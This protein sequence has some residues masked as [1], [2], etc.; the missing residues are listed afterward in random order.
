MNT[1][2]PAPEHDA[3]VT[4]PTWSKRVSILVTLCIS[5]K[6]E[7]TDAEVQALAKEMIASRADTPTSPG[8]MDISVQIERGPSD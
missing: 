7:P 4:N 1:A 6:E 3:A 2:F 8:V 5:R